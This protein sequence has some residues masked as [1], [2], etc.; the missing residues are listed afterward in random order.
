M[1][2][3]NQAIKHQS[4]ARPAHKGGPCPFWA[5]AACVIAILLASAGAFALE[6]EK[7]TTPPPRQQEQAAPQTAQSGRSPD[8][9]KGHDTASRR[10]A[11]EPRGIIV[12]PDYPIDIDIWTD[13][14]EYEEGESLKIFFQSSRD[15]FVYIF[16]VDSR[17]RTHQI[18]PN[19]FDRDNYIEGGWR[20]RIPDRRY[21]FVVTG[22]G[23]REHLK[24]VAIPE[25][26]DYWEHRYSPSR[27][28][29][30]P[31][32]P[33]GAEKFLEELRQRGPSSQ[34]AP[35]GPSP[36]GTTPDRVERGSSETFENQARSGEM[37]ISRIDPVP[38]HRSH[39]PRYAVAWTSFYVLDRYHRPDPDYPHYHDEGT[40]IINTVPEFASVLI[41]GEYIGRTPLEINLP[42]G[43]YEV[44][45][46]KPGYDSWIKTVNIKEGRKTRYSFKLR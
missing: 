46:Y 33:G 40:L 29:P 1:N 2:T 42:E 31:E 15:A 22:P 38:N 19:Y 20:Y 43:R 25:R 28:K 44:R 37:R 34:N 30:Y 13:R 5:T 39:Q 11:P 45:V 7:A 35:S 26:F 6:R 12:V 23:G 3:I 36:R 21:N 4:T 8:S 41:N 27:S 18:F 16:N 14:Y 10:G 32:A 17:G 9:A 24:I